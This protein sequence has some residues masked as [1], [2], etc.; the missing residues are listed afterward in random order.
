MPLQQQHRTTPL[1]AR[2]A[3]VENAA[4]STRSPT[5]PPSVLH[6]LCTV[7]SAVCAPLVS[8]SIATYTASGHRRS[9][10]RNHA[11]YVPP[12]LHIRLHPPNLSPLKSTPF[13]L[14]TRAGAA[15]IDETASP[16]QSPSTD[17]FPGLPSIVALVNHT[18]HPRSCLE[19][20][21]ITIPTLC[22]P[23]R[24]QLIVLITTTVAVPSHVDITL[25]NHCSIRLPQARRQ[26]YARPSLVSSGEAPKELT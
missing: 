24:C 16:C 10:S 22:E 9:P 23:P 3:D 2:D 5:L 21:V 11:S 26:I 18:I 13:C 17:I 25:R 6:S 7:C 4:H 12:Y 19:S 20:H 14:R 1:R 15:A 8:A